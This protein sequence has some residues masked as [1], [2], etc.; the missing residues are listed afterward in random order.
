MQWILLVKHIEI[1]CKE[2]RKQSRLESDFLN[3]WQW[4]QP[5]FNSYWMTLKTKWL[6]SHL[7][8]SAWFGKY[9][10]GVPKQKVPILASSQE[11][12][13]RKP[14]KTFQRKKDS[15][16]ITQILSQIMYWSS[17]LNVSINIKKLFHVL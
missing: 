9:P 11:K 2:K 5:S 4:K 8:Y 7:F 15:T 10:V 16:T 14:N 13:E 3:N 17:Y 12:R 6:Y 1:F